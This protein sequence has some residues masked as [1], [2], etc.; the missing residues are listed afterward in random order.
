MRQSTIY[1]VVQTGTYA[2]FTKAEMDTEF[3]RFKTALTASGSRLIGS[4]VNGE[5]FQFGPRSDWN[6]HEWGRQVRAAMAQ[7]SPDF[8]APSQTIGVRF[9]D[10]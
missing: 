1:A 3:A 2:G 6:L 8:L 4:S 9:S 7:V 5:S 10:C